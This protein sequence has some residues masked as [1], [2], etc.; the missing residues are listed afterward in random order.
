MKCQ[1]F[2]LK[3]LSSEKTIESTKIQIKAH[4]T[5]DP[6]L[7]PEFFALGKSVDLVTSYISSKFNSATFT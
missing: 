4:P 2:D 6:Q 3:Y 7:N 5:S 1:V